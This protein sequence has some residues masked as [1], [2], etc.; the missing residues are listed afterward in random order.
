MIGLLKYAYITSLQ[1]SWYA[2]NALL[3]NYKLNNLFFRNKNNIC[4]LHSKD[5]F[6]AFDA[7][8]KWAI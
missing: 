8:E 6:L 4:T 2:T 3:I 5:F 1:R 7:C